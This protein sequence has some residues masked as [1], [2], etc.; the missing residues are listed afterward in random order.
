MA[1]HFAGTSSDLCRTMGLTIEYSKFGN[2]SDVEDA[3]RGWAT[4]AKLLREAD[5]FIVDHFP[6]EHAPDLARSFHER[7]DAGAR[8]LVLPSSRSG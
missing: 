3:K 6:L 1:T 4:A 8:A 5:A 7:I 2:L